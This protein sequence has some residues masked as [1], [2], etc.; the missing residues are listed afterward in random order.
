[1]K[2][3]TQ[4][5]ILFAAILGLA[6]GFGT[7]ATAQT[8]FGANVV[9]NQMVLSGAL[10]SAGGAAPVLSGCATISASVG[11]PTAGR[12]QTSG[13]SCTLVITF[14]T[15]APNGWACNAKDIT[16]PADTV[17]EVSTTTTSATFAGTTVAADNI[18]YFCIGY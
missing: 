12:F 7:V 6:L 8:Y 5:K 1:M 11:G 17:N 10:V 13:T 9:G 2:L 16:T 4:V 3:F 15:A 18:V 14:A